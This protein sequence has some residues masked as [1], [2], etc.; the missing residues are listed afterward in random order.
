[1][2]DEI[3]AGSGWVITQ[4]LVLCTVHRTS[5]V[6]QSIKWSTVYGGSGGIITVYAVHKEPTVAA[7]GFAV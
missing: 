4:H 6:V 2:K 3:T 1:M 5:Y 7:V